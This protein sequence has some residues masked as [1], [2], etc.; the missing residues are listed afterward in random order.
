M[1]ALQGTC[2]TLKGINDRLYNTPYPLILIYIYY[3]GLFLF[4]FNV[5]GKLLL[6]FKGCPIEGN[7]V[8]GLTISRLY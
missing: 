3:Q 6:S 8:N 4:Y 7:A 5:A 2:V 1:A